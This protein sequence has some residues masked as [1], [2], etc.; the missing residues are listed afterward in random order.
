[1]QVEHIFSR[2][3][4]NVNRNEIGMVRHIAELAYT[5]TRIVFNYGMC[6]HTHTHIHTDAVWG[7][8]YKSNPHPVRAPHYS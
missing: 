2:V 4:K 7:K 5:R 8:Q 3:I 1:M 6:P